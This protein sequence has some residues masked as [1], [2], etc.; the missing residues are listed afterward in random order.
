LAI[1]T[2]RRRGH[3][4][5]FGATLTIGTAF[6]RRR[7]AV[8]IRVIATFFVVR[9]ARGL[10]GARSA[11]PLL[12][13][14]TLHALTLF[15]LLTLALGALRAFVGGLEIIELLLLV[16][17][18]LI[19]IALLLEQ[20][21]DLRRKRRRHPPALATGAALRTLTA[22]TTLAL[23]PTLSGLAL[24]PLRTLLAL[25]LRTLGSLVRGF[26]FVELL[27]FIAA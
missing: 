18:Q 27:A 8:A 9:L 13:L 10:R 20:R 4:S 1:H 15:A 25:A 24:L 16:A 11:L 3:P 7:H 12:S 21:F 19:A 23:R 26:E 6:R 5:A 22:R 2:G 17:A 14:V